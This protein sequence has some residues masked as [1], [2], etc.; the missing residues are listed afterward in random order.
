M[1]LLALLVGVGLVAIIVAGLWVDYQCNWK[2]PPEL[3][4][5]DV[6]PKPADPTLSHR[7]SQDIDRPRDR[8]P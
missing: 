3:R 5:F 4:G 2:R 8:H 1:T 6:I 7:V